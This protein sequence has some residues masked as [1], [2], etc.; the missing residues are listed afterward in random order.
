MDILT[1][2]WDVSRKITSNTSTRGDR[3]STNVVIGDLVI[4][5]RMDKATPKIFIESCC[6]RGK[7]FEIHLTKTGQGSGSDEFMSY[8]TAVPLT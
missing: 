2:R 8:L 6:D 3:E 1:L 7:D 5:R 4:I